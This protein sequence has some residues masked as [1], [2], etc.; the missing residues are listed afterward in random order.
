MISKMITGDGSNICIKWVR[1]M[2]WKFRHCLEHLD[3]PIGWPVWCLHLEETMCT[4]L[5]RYAVPVPT[6]EKTNS[7]W[8]KSDHHQPKTPIHPLASHLYT[9][10]MYKY[11]IQLLFITHTRRVTCIT[12]YYL[13]YRQPETTSALSNSDS[14]RSLGF[15]VAVPKEG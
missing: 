11:K 2:I 13:N 12:T 15:Q 1:Q 14:A 9:V 5:Q 7:W 10:H 6:T 4:L 3:H 8:Q